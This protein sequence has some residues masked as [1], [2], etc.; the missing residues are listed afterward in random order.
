VRAKAS[1]A[2]AADLMTSPAITISRESTV[3]EAV[4]L[5]HA[6][7]VKRLPVEDTLGRL[8][9]I[10]S[11]SDLLAAFL[12]PDEEIRSEVEEDLIRH[13]VDDVGESYVT[14][15]RSL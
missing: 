10:L 8:V 1:G 6:K 2:V 12:R 15:T 13:D 11:R 14:V 3:V 5:L 9:G 7:G 4:R